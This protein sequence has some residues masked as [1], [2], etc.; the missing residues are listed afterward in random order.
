MTPRFFFQEI[1]K[2]KV[3]FVEA[4]KIERGEIEN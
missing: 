2:M 3:F 4:E 1:E